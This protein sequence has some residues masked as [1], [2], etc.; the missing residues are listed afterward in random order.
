MQGGVTATQILVI[1]VLII[2]GL[3]PAHPSYALAQ[4]I[5]PPR[6]VALGSEIAIALVLVSFAYSGWNGAAYVAGEVR[7]PSR[8]LPVALVLGTGLVTALYVGVN[9]VY[10]AAVPVGDLAGVI[11]VAHVVARKLAGPS[12]GRV[13]SG[14]VALVL[15]SSV[16]AMVMAGSRV[17]E[18]MGC[19]YRALSFLARRTSRGAPAVAMA[20]Q[21]AL[22]VVMVVT[23]SFGTLLA[24][25]G[26]TLSVS[27]GLT[28]LGVLVLRAREPELVR[29][30]RAWGYPA[31][32]LL[33]V[34]LSAWMVGR[35]LVE[36]PSSSIAGVAIIAAALA[37][38]GIV[39]RAGA[40]KS[41]AAPT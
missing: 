10:L 11:E 3:A 38:Y 13:L 27:A 16:G 2:A 20:I 23:S 37:L 36:R 26:F 8:T 32:P 18:A 41:S 33:F 5:P 7:E 14:V 21:A 28:V 15:A 24:F 9:L 4:R 12:A 29:P 40:A 30:Y 34:A 35:S 31:T 1:I 17:Y 39:A 25:I 6:A 19:D 22:A